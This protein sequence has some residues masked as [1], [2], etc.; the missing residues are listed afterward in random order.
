MEWEAQGRGS[1][2]ALKWMPGEKADA[3]SRRDGD[4]VL[5]RYMVSRSSPC[6]LHRALVHSIF[7]SGIIIH[8]TETED[9]RKRAEGNTGQLKRFDR[10]PRLA[11]THPL[12]SLLSHAHKAREPV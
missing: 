5:E 10:S 8:K 4:E 12:S 9:A 6:E 7:S 11:A 3:G 1:R 2:C